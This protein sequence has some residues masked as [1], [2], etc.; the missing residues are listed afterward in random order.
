MINGGLRLLGTMPWRIDDETLVPEAGSCFTCPKRSGKHPLLFDAEEASDDGKVVK[1]DRCLDPVCYVNK[2]VAHLKRCECAARAKHPDLQLVQIGYS[3][4]HTRVQQEFGER[5]TRVYNPKIVKAGAKGAVPVMQVD[6]PKAGAVVYIAAPEPVNL[7]RHKAPKMRPRDAHGKPIPL[8]LT[9]R[10][11]RLQKRRDA[12]L[13]DKVEDLL[14]DMTAE[15]LAALVATLNDRESGKVE[16]FDPLAL[17]VAFGT[18]HCEHRPDGCAAWKRYEALANGTAESPA[19]AALHEVV[20]V[21]TRRLGGVH[22][23]TV[24]DQA[25]DARRI[26]SFL[27]LDTAGIEANAMLAIPTPKS[28]AHEMANGQRPAS[29]G[30]EE[31]DDAG[32]DDGTDAVDEGHGQDDECPFEPNV[33][34]DRDDMPDDVPEEDPDEDEE[35]VVVSGRRASPRARAKSGKTK[36]KGPKAKSARS[37][38]R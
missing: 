13:V 6:G 37:A 1:G 18:G 15:R 28:W 14:R 20:K 3:G 9:E 8:P 30:S 29:F 23:N 7:E 26:C 34:D 32:G 24:T 10:K 27:G 22:P 5:T 36:P 12:F 21:W 38:R 31:A 35:E 11:L 33:K 4:P 25:A 2:E 17:V 19:L 16:R